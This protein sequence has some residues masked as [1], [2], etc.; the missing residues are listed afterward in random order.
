MLNYFCSANT[1]QVGSVT[2]L[3]VGGFTVVDQVNRDEQRTAVRLGGSGGFVQHMRQARVQR[4]KAGLHVLPH[5]LLR[6]LRTPDVTT[7][8]WSACACSSFAAVLSRSPASMFRTAH[9]WAVGIQRL[10]SLFEQTDRYSRV[11]LTRHTQ[12]VLGTASLH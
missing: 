2:R 3:C 5:R 10:S 1:K 8:Q 11:R 7:R 9:R 4:R 6:N 12:D